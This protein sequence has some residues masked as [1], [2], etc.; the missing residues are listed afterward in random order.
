MKRP[1]QP[2]DNRKKVNNLVAMQDAALRQNAFWKE[3]MIL[4]MHAKGLKS[5]VV[6]SEVM[7]SLSKSCPPNEIAYIV[8]T[9][10]NDD[11]KDI[12]FTLH[13]AYGTTERDAIIA[14]RTLPVGAVVVPPK[15]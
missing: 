15:S 1:Q 2:S 10:T 13:L 6:G 7:T 8:S 12:G 9:K 3:T 14:S 5:I 11:P 4:A